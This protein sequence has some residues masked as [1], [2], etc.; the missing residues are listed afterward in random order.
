MS[1]RD[2]ASYDN[3]GGKGNRRNII[4]VT[5][6]LEIESGNISDL[7]DGQNINTLKFKNQIIA[8]KVILFDFKR[9]V[10][11]T[12]IKGFSVGTVG[13]DNGTFRVEV[14]NDGVMWNDVGF[15]YNSSNIG[16]EARLY[17]GH[18]FF[19]YYRLKGA[20]SQSKLITP[21]FQ[22]LEFNIVSKPNRSLFLFS[23]GNY[24]SAYLGNK[25]LVPRMTSNTTPRGVA[26]SEDVLQ[27]F[28]VYD[29]YKA[30]DGGS[31]NFSDANTIQYSIYQSGKTYGYVGYEFSEPKKVIK[32]SVTGNPSSLDKR[33]PST[34][35]LEGSNDGANWISLDYQN[36]TTFTGSFRVIECKIAE[37][38]I[39]EYK[40]YRLRWTKNNGDAWT[41]ISEI[42]LFGDSYIFPI[43]DTLAENMFDE[44]GLDTL[45]DIPD[46]LWA[47]L[48]DI[49]PEFEIVTLVPPLGEKPKLK[50]HIK[51]IPLSIDMDALPIEQLTVQPSDFDLHGSLLSIVANKLPTN[52][53]DG[54]CKFIV[55]FDNGVTWEVFR[56]GKWRTVNAADM[57]K[58]REQGMSF[59]A[60][61]QIKEKHLLNK[62]KQIRI[63][64][65][66]DDS[67]HRE[68]EVKLDHSQLIVKSALDDVKFE[69]MTFHLLNT[70]A[71]IQLQL[72][73]NKLTGE[74]DDADKGKVQY[75]VLLN[76]KPYYPDNGEFTRLASS[77]LDINLYISEREILFN[78]ENKL[79]VEFQDYWGQT[80]QWETTF[81]GTYSGLMFMD[82]T[83][84]YYSDTFGGIL[85]YLDFGIIIAGQT[86]VD[87]KVIVKNQLGYEI[88]NLT[89]EVVKDS[90]PQ[91]VT[92][93]LSR[94]NK[95]FI[96]QDKLLFSQIFQQD[97]TVEFYVRIATVIEAEPTV[98]GQFEIRAKADRV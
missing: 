38:K 91:G 46:E 59:K 34:W 96:A 64:Y 51:D 32:Y 42:Q 13:V 60:L 7:I 23:D 82:K 19:R 17:G 3:L 81:I 48:K 62:G 92:I 85:K 35:Y 98:N 61:A 67:I 50:K 75:R 14:S 28:Y 65:Y 70:T 72:T 78:Q 58:V 84:N 71:T 80:D 12:H 40:F 2:K 94:S 45:D 37:Q 33:N 39:S 6:D 47:S 73:G 11:I 26:F 5:T 25:S 89:L 49:S 76:D 41:G 36:W 27:D 22:E 53:Y 93:E 20:N 88:T 68:E 44:F 97:D 54:I 79:T 31:R 4:E 16:L 83:G 43:G 30:F 24:Y 10:L 56:N 55:S 63:G 52:T 21:Q 77:P 74:L 18:D 69:D 57:V 90:L 8:D 66:L 29:S 15:F 87:Q 95:P 1:Y 86:T 9:P